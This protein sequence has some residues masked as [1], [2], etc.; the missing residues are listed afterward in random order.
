MEQQIEA[1]FQKMY[2]VLIDAVPVLV[3]LTIITLLLFK[4]NK[5]LFNNI[6]KLSMRS[7]HNL[8]EVQTKEY[9]KRVDT[10]TSIG[11]TILDII[12]I[13]VMVM[14]F[15]KRIGI[16]I[17]PLLTGAGIVGIAIGF[18]SQE[19]VKDMIS[20]LFLLMENHIRA[21]DVVEINGKSGLVEKIGLR[22][23]LLRDFAGVVHIFQNGKI[24]TL[25]NM[26]KDWSAMMFEIG[27][28]YKEDVD[29]VMRVMKEVGDDLRQDEEF[30]HK[31]LEDLEIFGVDKFASSAVIIKARLKTKP[32][33]QW[34]VGRE[35]RRRLK[36]KFDSV[37]IE[38]PFPQ[39]TL[40]WG[41]NIQ[42]LKIDIDKV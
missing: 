12:V 37:N 10:L 39:T 21:G 20:G 2:E 28:A 36:N 40:H 38:I 1:F 5:V 26:T 9:E 25:S 16:E 35:Y 15:L 32:I 33:E 14:V 19:L 7:A 8:D 13:I 18:G 6:H 42:P 3:V 27:V 24:D 41:K 30:K 23:V 17:A 31:I 22:T 34:G 11:K 29:E 4:I